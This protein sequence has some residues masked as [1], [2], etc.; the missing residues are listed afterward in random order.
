MGSKAEKAADSA[1]VAFFSSMDV[2]IGR[3]ALGFITG[4]ASFDGA[5][6]F[7][8]ISGLYLVGGLCV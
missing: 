2:L 7:A 5:F 6:R 8:D 4:I 3:R 1:T